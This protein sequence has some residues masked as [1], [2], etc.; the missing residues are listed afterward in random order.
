MT[1]DR[2][3]CSNAPA[4]GGDKARETE[5]SALLAGE[6]GGSLSDCE[7]A[8]LSAS[9]PDS[10]SVHFTPQWPPSRKLGG[11][12]FP[13]KQRSNAAGELSGVIEE[14]AHR[15]RN[16][17]TRE[18]SLVSVRPRSGSGQRGVG[19]HNHALG[20]DEESAGSIVARKRV[21]ARGAKRPCCKHANNKRGEA[22]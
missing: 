18:T 10:A 5:R 20:Q 4:R 16:R 8:S 13:V 3:T 12:T 6:G 21:K 2:S 14:S 19:N 1:I 7:G 9:E 11:L 15:K 22:A 17:V